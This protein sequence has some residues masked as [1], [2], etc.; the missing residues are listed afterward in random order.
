MDQHCWSKIS[1]D[2]ILKFSSENI[3]WSYSSYNL[4]VEEMWKELHGK[5]S[6]FIDIVPT[7][8]FESSNQPLKPLWGSSALKCM[9]LNK[10]KVW[11]VLDYS[12][13][14]PG[15]PVL[16]M[17]KIKFSIVLDKGEPQLPD[18]FYRIKKYWS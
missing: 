17:V 1:I 14:G 12:L 8:R 15:V 3:I 16:E 5:L 13:R 10:D 7:A 18:A 11:D 4:N 2:N 6:K 9:G